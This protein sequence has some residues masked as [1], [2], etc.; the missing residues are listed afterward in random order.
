M[1]CRFRTICL[2][3]LFCWLLSSGA[4]AASFSKPG[5]RVRLKAG[6]LGSVSISSSLKAF[7]GWRDVLA[8]MEAETDC[9]R[10]LA[11]TGGEGTSVSRSF[12]RGILMAEGLSEERML[13]VVNRY[14]NR[15]PY[16]LDVELHGVADYWASPG[17]FLEKAGDCEDYAIVKFAALKTL[18]FPS[19]RLR[20][21]VVKDEIRNLAHA[22]LAVRVS[23]DYRI[24]DSLSDLV[25]SHTRYRHY[26]PKY[27]V[28]D[29]RSWAHAR[30]RKRTVPL[31]REGELQ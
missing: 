23:G 9:Y 6:L 24:L 30:P 21:V 13:V 5:K 22:V 10:W 28:N 11:A 20:I 14:F 8:R 25:V 7:P 15:W 27:S 19:E 12:N 4:G 18:G 2:T 29:M 31:R 16:R 3:A 1:A 26:M 17:E